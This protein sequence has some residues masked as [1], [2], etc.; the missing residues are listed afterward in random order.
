MKMLFKIIHF[1]IV[2][3]DDFLKI[4][5]Q[6]LSRGQSNIAAA[7]RTVRLDVLGSTANRPEVADVVIALIGGW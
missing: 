2:N 7:L 1:Q 3:K 6:R 5:S 4:N